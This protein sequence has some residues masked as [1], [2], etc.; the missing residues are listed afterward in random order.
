ML[1]ADSI[2]ANNNGQQKLCSNVNMVCG[3]VCLYADHM[4]YKNISRM[5]PGLLLDFV[6]VGLCVLFF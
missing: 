2:T 4:N 1:S 6:Y 3:R 5:I